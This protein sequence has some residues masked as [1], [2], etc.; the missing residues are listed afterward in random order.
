MGMESKKKYSYVIKPLAVRKIR[1]FYNN[2]FHKYHNVYSYGDMLSLIDKTIAGIYSIE[3]DSLR[4]KPILQRW[5]NYHMAHVGIW[6]YA[7]SVGEDVITIHDACH[8][9]NMK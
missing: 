6:Y 7:Y 8:N 2:V 4:R 1:S 3:T 5:S 9:L